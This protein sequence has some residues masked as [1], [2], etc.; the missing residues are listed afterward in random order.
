[1]GYPIQTHQQQ[2][3]RAKRAHPTWILFP[4]FPLRPHL[5]ASPISVP[6]SCSGPLRASPCVGEGATGVSYPLLS[7]PIPPPPRIADTE[8]CAHR[9]FLRIAEVTV[10]HSEMT[11]ATG[12]IATEMGL[13]PPGTVGSGSPVGPAVTGLTFSV[14]GEAIAGERGGV[15][16]VVDSGAFEL[17]RSCGGGGGDYV[18]LQELGFGIVRCRW[19]FGKKGMPGLQRG[20]GLCWGREERVGDRSAGG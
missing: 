18:K 2:L 4:F 11:R 7:N 19:S 13:G 5:P 8:D 3:R 16:G 12:S 15:G 14:S 20:G 9:A 1:M 10:I 6:R 17:R